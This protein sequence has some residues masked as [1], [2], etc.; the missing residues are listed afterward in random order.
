MS[1]RLHN[2]PRSYKGVG[3]FNRYINFTSF[4]LLFLGVV[5]WFTLNS[6]LGLYIPIASN[7]I[8]FLV[9]LA[10]YLLYTVS[11]PIDYYN[12]LGGERVFKLFYSTYIHKKKNKIYVK[13]IRRE[14]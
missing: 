11:V 8:G 14:E 13:E 12:K 7:V 6:T 5:I 4:G 9:T 3:Q 10:L 2:F 1:R